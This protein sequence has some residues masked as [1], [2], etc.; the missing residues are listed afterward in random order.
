MREQLKK[1]IEVKSLVTLPLVVAFIVLALRGV[2][3]PDKFMMVFLMVMTYFFT[4][5]KDGA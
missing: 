2:I 5:K 1:L 3:D 4:R